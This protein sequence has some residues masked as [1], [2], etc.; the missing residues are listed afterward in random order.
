MASN[1]K[2]LKAFV[3]MDGTGRVV[4]SSLI[5]ARKMPKVGNWKQVQAYQCCDPFI[6]SNDFLLMED[7]LPND[8]NFILQEEGGRIIL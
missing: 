4:P 2:D 3:R 1:K 6:E 7:S 8:Q 5:L